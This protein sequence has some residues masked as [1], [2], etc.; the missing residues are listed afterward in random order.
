MA[1][2]GVISLLNVIKPF[3]KS[4]IRTI[5]KVIPM[6]KSGQMQVV[7]RFTKLYRLKW[8]F[9]LPNSYECELETTHETFRLRAI[10]PDIQLS[11]DNH[12]TNTSHN[13]KSWE[14]RYTGNRFFDPSGKYG[15]M[16]AR[17]QATYTEF[18]S[19]G[20]NPMAVLE[21]ALVSWS[22]LFNKP[23]TEQLDLIKRIK[24]KFIT[25]LDFG[26]VPDLVD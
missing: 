25:A 1:R 4:I 12:I 5:I 26:E 22:D 18:C 16:E 19:L 21:K 24:S 7:Y 3:R 9:H 23:T 10:F 15:T 14:S 13:F 20:Y 2:I 6:E 8:L 17:Y 11:H